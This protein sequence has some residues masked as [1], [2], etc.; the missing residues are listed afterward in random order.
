MVHLR[1]GRAV[2]ITPI[3]TCL[4]ATYLRLTISRNHLN[5][6]LNNAYMCH[7]HHPYIVIIIIATNRILSCLTPGWAFFTFLPCIQK[8]RF[9][10][11][12]RPIEVR[13]RPPQDAN[14]QI[15][16]TKAHM[17]RLF[18][19]I[20]WLING[21]VSGVTQ[22]ITRMWSQFVNISKARLAD[23]GNILKAKSYHMGL[24]NIQEMVTQYLLS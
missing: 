6:K 5:I 7:I 8:G 3:H 11:K 13:L 20:L 15:K 19:E 1:L 4:W 12:K 9:H 14:Y 18:I 17:S 21:Y 24:N 16:Q 10:G 22:C 2:T 23:I